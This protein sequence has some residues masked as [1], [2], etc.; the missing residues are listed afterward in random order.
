MLDHVVQCAAV[1]VT[2]VLRPTKKKVV[3]KKGKK[4]AAVAEVFPIP[5]S[6]V[7]PLTTMSS[8]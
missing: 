8:L 2:T 4:K 7:R 5:V 6:G 1:S 3:K